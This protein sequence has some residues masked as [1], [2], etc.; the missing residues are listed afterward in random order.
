[1]VDIGGQHFRQQLFHPTDGD[2]D[3]DSDDD[4]AVDSTLSH[5]CQQQR[6]Q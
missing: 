5:D 3:G 6:I 4:D 1:M 2:D